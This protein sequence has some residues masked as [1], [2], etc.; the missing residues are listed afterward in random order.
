MRPVVMLSWRVAGRPVKALVMAEVEIGFGAIVSDE[1]LAVLVRRHRSR[2]D[3][4]IGVQFAQADLV[5]A[6]LQERA[7]SL[8]RPDLCRERRPRRR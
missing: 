8:Q 7:E 3:V 2:V 6:R 5:P 4:E 1:H